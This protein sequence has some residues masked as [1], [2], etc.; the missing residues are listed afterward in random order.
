MLPETQKDI[1]LGRDRQLKDLRKMMSGFLTPDNALPHV[2]LIWGQGGI[3]KSALLREFLRLVENEYAG[4]FRTLRV[5]WEEQRTHNHGVLNVRTED[6]DIEQVLRILLD[7][8]GERLGLA[9]VFKK[10][11][12]VKMRERIEHAWGV[13]EEARK[14]SEAPPRATQPGDLFKPAEDLV[15]DLAITAVTGDPGL[16]IWKS[17]TR[18]GMQALKNLLAQNKLRLPNIDE[19]LL[20][21]GPRHLAQALGKDLRVAAADWPILVALDTYE[22][23]DVVD[24]FLREVIKAAGPRVAWVIVGRR[25]LYETYELRSGTREV[26]YREEEDH[27]Y[28]IRPI[29]LHALARP[30]IREYF[31]QAAPGRPVLDDE[32][33]NAVNRSTRA[34]PLAIRLAAAIWNDT[35]DI[36]HIHNEDGLTNEDLLSRMI[37]RYELHCVDEYD[38]HA[39]AAIAMAEGDTEILKAMLVPECDVRKCA[40]EAYIQRVRERYSAV[41]RQSS[42]SPRLHDEPAR[43]YIEHLRG[44]W[45]TE[46]WVRT[47]AQRASEHCRK[48]MQK[49]CAYH[50]RL[51]E[52]AADKNYIEA[53]RKLINYLFWIQEDEACRLLTLRFLEGISYSQALR[54]AVLEMGESWRGVLD[55]RSRKRLNMLREGQHVWDTGARLR[56]MMLLEKDLER[57]WL[58]EEDQGD[59][60]AGERSAIK[61]WM[62]AQGLRYSGRLS[63]AL[64]RIVKAIN[65]CPPDLETPLRRRLSDEALGISCQQD[66]SNHRELGV[67]YNWLRRHGKAL[68]HFLKAVELDPRSLSEN[69]RKTTPTY[70]P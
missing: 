27:S 35:G 4:R 36:H 5:D 38:R 6:L 26:G 46:E 1:F 32:Q 20:T 61:L 54:D 45:R 2:A 69:R 25:D 40:Y 11:A 67:T 52:L 55:D 31:R 14:R 22:I 17:A 3:G 30:D 68:E 43:F 53:S 62:E 9:A 42:S 70:Q 47:Y 34:I 56:L 41:Q 60:H 29:D 24:P 37:A 7:A 51:H 13:F 8:A 49:P 63:E 19:T 12:F 23:V 33:L 57:R 28:H 59:A 48:V 65:W 18:F 44:A 66:E 10:G 15:K 58:P 64:D 16:G 39:L 50:T 21:A